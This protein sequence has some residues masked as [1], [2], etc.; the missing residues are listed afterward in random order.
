[1]DT[2]GALGGEGKINVLRRILS[3]RQD[4]L[5]KAERKL[6]GDLR[7]AL[8]RFEAADEHQ[9]TLDRS[10]QQL[11]EFF[12]LVVIGEFNAG[13]SA[14][15]NAL[16][17]HRILREGVTPTTA[18]VNVLRYGE[19]QRREIVEEQLEVL[20]APIDLLNEIHIVD[21]PGTNAINREHER[22]TAE[23][24]P[25]SDLVLFITSVDRPFTESERVFLERTRDWGK[26][27]VVVLNKIDILAEGEDITEVQ[28]FVAES[29]HHLLG[30]TPEIFPVS[31]RF[32]MRAKQGEQELWEPS[33][34]QTLER[35]VHETLDESGR[36]RLKLLNPLGVGSHLVS[37]YLARARERLAVLKKDFAML[38][39]VERQLALYEEDMGREFNLRLADLAKILG[40][41]ERRGHHY[42]DDVM[43]LGRVLDLLNTSRVQR[44]F[45][46]QV[47]ADV[48]QQIE[49]RVGQLIDWLVDSDFRQWQAVRNH[50]AQRRE[51]HRDRIVG[52]SE[53]DGFHYDREYLI[54]SVGRE[55]QRVVETYDRSYEA[56]QIAEGARAAV[57]AAAA[58]EAS[59]LGLGTLVSILATSVAVDV[60]G[61]LMASAMAV[62][63]F[64][65][66]PARRRR[67][68]REMG[69]KV[70][71]M[72]ARLETTLR[73][74]F[75]HELKRSV[76][77]IREGIAPYGRFVRAERAK[78]DGAQ[79]DFESIHLEIERLKAQVEEL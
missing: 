65:I 74:Q 7:V 69:Q 60:T 43:R 56:Q 64:F 3:D 1:M 46:Q 12:L 21:T 5:L 59:A 30:L 25:R 18:Q 24:V 68:K 23:F 58:V 20:T 13:K 47:I 6:L 9:V 26:K 49:R 73:K 67:A 75:D 45:E 33:G 10:I 70:T 50:L 17:G 11:D 36:I 35:F 66:V 71:D 52:D 57:A 41:M 14:F 29:A 38:E 42:F 40:D 19:A 53:G 2:G 22:I 62:V 77:R 27:I 31:A 15:I 48:P 28:S 72:R 63:G 61:I 54:D 76:A 37:V 51:A 34:F 32:A 8:A 4:E 79:L 44:G 55:A 39:D 78:L 16:L